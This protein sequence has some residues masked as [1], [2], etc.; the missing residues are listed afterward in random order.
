G[1]PAVQDEGHSGSPK[2]VVISKIIYSLPFAS[3]SK[4]G[5][6]G[7]AGISLVCVRDHSVTQRIW[8]AGAV[9]ISMWFKCDSERILRPET[10]VLARY[11]NFDT[12]T[13]SRLAIK[14]SPK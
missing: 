8:Q 10:V 2:S 1:D 11:S 14:V 4:Q 6:V 3:S 7:S 9:T 5:S 13:F 12:S